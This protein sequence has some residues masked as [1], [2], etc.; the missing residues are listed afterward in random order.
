MLCMR[1]LPVNAGRSSKLNF[2]SGSAVGS[3]L[4]ARIWHDL[5]DHH[6][7]LVAQLGICNSS[8]AASATRG[9]GICN[10]RRASLTG[11]AASATRGGHLDS[12]RGGIRSWEG[13]CGSWRRHLRLARRG[14]A[15]SEE[16]CDS[17]GQH[18]RTCDFAGGICDSST[19]REIISETRVVSPL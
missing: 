3:Q 12:E 4:T 16:A 8:E 14:H 5:A 2:K 17:R 13:I 11:E 19:S 18:L 10:S 7:L 6:A 1:G 9:G 15:A